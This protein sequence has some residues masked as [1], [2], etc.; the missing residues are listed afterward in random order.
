MNFIR[1]L[2]TKSV[3]FNKTNKFFFK[4]KM[5]LNHLDLQKL[6]K[7]D[8][9]HETMT[10]KNDWFDEGIDIQSHFYHE[11]LFNI[12]SKLQNKKYIFFL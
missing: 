10:E 7:M 5:G 2:N 4:K 6:I 9:D 8:I 11:F 3:N 1:R 12:I